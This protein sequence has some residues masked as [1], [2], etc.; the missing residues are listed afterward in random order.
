MTLTTDEAFA[1]H[2]MALTEDFT[3]AIVKLTQEVVRQRILEA[4]G[5]V[6][7]PGGPSKPAKR[8]AKR[9]AT[10]K[11]NRIPSSTYVVGKR[12]GNLPGWLVAAGVKN[13]ADA[14]KRFPAGTV[15]RKGSPLLP[16]KK[17]RKVKAAPV[18]APAA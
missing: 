5:A 13:S 9:K 8:K 3:K 18:E 17:P 12:K 7:G 16:A 2:L 4:A 15:L 1:V 14:K 11:R 10:K 6:G